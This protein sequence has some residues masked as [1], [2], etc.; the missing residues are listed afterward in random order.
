[1]LALAAGAAVLLGA[2]WPRRS[3]WD[4]AVVLFPVGF[5]ALVSFSSAPNNRYVLPIVVMAHLLAALAVV[6]AVEAIPA[7]RLRPAAR[8]AGTAAFVGAMATGLGSRCA[9]Y[10][11]Q[12]RDD[13]RLK[14]RQW[15]AENLPPGTIILQDTLAGLLQPPWD[16]EG[17]GPGPGGTTVIGFNFA[18]EV[19]EFAD[20]RNKGAKYV[21]VCDLAY[22]RY[23]DPFVVPAAGFEQEFARRKAWYERL[24]REG[25]LLK[26]WRP[27]PH[28][29]S[30]TNPTVRIYRL[31]GQ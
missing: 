11:G 1:V 19:G 17:T 25:E 3:A 28:T 12:F 22:G 9:N 5:L 31:P 6:W 26:E 16:D 18:P 21:A 10:I 8:W 2:T 13:G 14:A 20:A 27:E 24:F 7:G 23:V 15:V 4:V 30:N 29:H